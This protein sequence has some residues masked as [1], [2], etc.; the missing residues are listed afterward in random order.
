MSSL[1]ISIWVKASHVPEMVTPTG[2]GNRTL[3]HVISTAEPTLQVSQSQAAPLGPLLCQEPCY[4]QSPCPAALVATTLQQQQQLN[5]S[6]AL[7]NQEI[8]EVESVTNRSRNPV[9]TTNN[10]CI[11]CPGPCWLVLFSMT[12][13]TVTPQ[14]QQMKRKNHPRSYSPSSHILSMGCFHGTHHLVGLKWK[15]SCI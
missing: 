7:P 10:C 13:V 4:L 12:P 3:W 11:N 15:W 5:R 9:L 6:P 14:Q 8:V 2:T 1:S